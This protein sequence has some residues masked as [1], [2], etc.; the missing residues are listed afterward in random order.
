MVAISQQQNNKLKN[1][2]SILTYEDVVAWLD[3]SW[4]NAEPVNNDR[5][6]SLDK[7]LG[8]PSQSF[9]SIIV[10]G[11]N[12]K[13]LTVNFISQLLREEKVTVGAYYSPHINNYTERFAIN[14]EII[15]IQDFTATAQEVFNASNQLDE[16]L[17]ATEILTA[18]AFLSFK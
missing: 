4:S 5:V 8:N 3:S 14:N 12:G 17:H 15:N 9:K 13:S 10:S 11:D 18:I 1:V 7:I 2:N 6:K 16:N